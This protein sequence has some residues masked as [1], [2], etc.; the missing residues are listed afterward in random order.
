LSSFS[1]APAR[2]AVPSAIAP[3]P[4]EVASV[5]TA[6]E[7]SPSTLLRIPTTRF[8]LPKAVLP[9]PKA[10]AEPVFLSVAISFSGIV[11]F[12]LLSWGG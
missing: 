7:L 10:T 2:D 1:A 3:V 9:I 11:F 6:I 5:P 8:S 12:P 4:F